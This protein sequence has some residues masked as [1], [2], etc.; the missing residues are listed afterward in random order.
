[1]EKFSK[2]VGLDTHKETI[3]MS[4]ADAAGGE[5]RYFGEVANRPAAI[6]KLLKRLSPDGEVVSYCYEAGPCG[7]V[8]IAPGKAAADSD[9]TNVGGPHYP[10]PAVGNW[11][12][13]PRI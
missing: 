4:V 3:A 10:M 13:L 6:V 11:N 12:I 1:M 9:T 5:A 8:Q 2:Y 7:Y